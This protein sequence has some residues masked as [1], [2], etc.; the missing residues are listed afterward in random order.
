MLLIDGKRKCS[1]I[2]EELSKLYGVAQELLLPDVE[3][4]LGL[5]LRIGVVVS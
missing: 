2:T 4:F 3:Q 5:L 1:S